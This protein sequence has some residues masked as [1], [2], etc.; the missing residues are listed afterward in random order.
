MSNPKYIGTAASTVGRADMVESAA[1][2]ASFLCLI[3][4]LAMPLLLATLPG[5]SALLGTGDALHVWLLA[6]A[7]PLSGVALWA[8]HRRHRLPYPLAIGAV[9]LSLL[10]AGVGIADS[11]SA[12]T[13]FTVAGS[14]TLAA[15]HFLNWRQRRAACLR[16]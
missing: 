5:I 7:I 6:L 12:E 16:S 2:G 1:L 4:C 14:L 13:I 10:A 15:A 3:H 9:G 8:G 11:E